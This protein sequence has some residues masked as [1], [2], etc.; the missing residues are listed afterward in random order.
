MPIVSYKGERSYEGRVIE[1]RERNYYD[2]SDFYAVVWDDEAGDIREIEYDTTRFGGG[3]NAWADLTPEWEADM[4]ARLFYKAADILMDAARHDRKTP[5][6]GK[7]V[8]V[9]AGRHKGL[10][11]VVI[12]QKMPELYGRREVVRLRLSPAAV[13]ADDGS[14]A[15]D[16][17]AKW[18]FAHNCRVTDP[19]VRDHIKEGCRKRAA[20]N[21]YGVVRGYR[22]SILA[23]A[24]MVMM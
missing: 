16:P 23:R 7:H 11:G 17:N 9:V 8:V 20:K 6:M 21:P 18:V 15:P 13:S 4:N 3:G 1:T 5:G 24:G 22:R 19:A 2:D 14:W 12:D 10:H